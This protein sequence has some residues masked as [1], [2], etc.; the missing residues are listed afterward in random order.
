MPRLKSFTPPKP[1]AKKPSM[2]ESLLATPHGRELL[3]RVS[4]Q[5]PEQ[6]VDDAADQVEKLINSLPTAPIPRKNPAYEGVDMELVDRVIR[7]EITKE[8]AMREIV[9][10]TTVF[11]GEKLAKPYQRFMTSHDAAAMVGSA[12]D[13]RQMP[14]LDIRPKTAR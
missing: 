3:L 8:E 13:K 1:K 5:A 9:G 7:G 6:G 10:D 14:P 11:E 2:A 4:E 12:M